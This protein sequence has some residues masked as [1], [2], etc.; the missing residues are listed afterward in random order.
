VLAWDNLGYTQDFV[1]S[2]RRHTDVP[3]ELIIVDNGSQWEAANY[4]G[5]AA[6]VAVLNET[7]LGFAPGMNCGLRVATGRH[8]AF[9]NNDTVLPPRWASRLVETADAH[10]R[11]GIVVPA[12]TAAGTPGTVRTE[13][14]ERIVVLPPF[15][16]PPPAVLYLMP[17]GVVKEIEGWGEEYLVASGED[18]DIGFKVWVNDL[19]IVF[20]ERV[21]VAHVGKASASKLGDWKALWDKNRYQFLAKWSG[22]TEVPRIAS[23][24]EQTFARN[25]AIAAST[26]EWMTKNF[27]A[28]DKPAKVREVIERS[29]FEQRLIRMWSRVPGAGH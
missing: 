29:P 13:P 22:D 1:E 18:V 7:N 11:A 24:D 3:Y 8:V 20:D 6:D 17:R 2:V 26:A 4:A 16:G 10:P 5:A 21:L 28:R 23:C 15:S 19:D 27:R 14:G 9:C 25:R 12:L